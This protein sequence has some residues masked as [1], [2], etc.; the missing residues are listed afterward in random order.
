MEWKNHGKDKDSW[1]DFHRAFGHSTEDCW[2]LRM[3]IEKLVQDGR[4]RHYIRR[5]VDRRGELPTERSKGQSS[6]AFARDKSRSRQRMT[7]HWGTIATII[8]GEGLAPRPKD[9][10]QETGREQEVQAVLT[11]AN[12][13]PLGR[14]DP[15]LVTTEI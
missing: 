12:L 10:M 7:P 6:G 3:Q 9:F 13:T 11:R 8:S 2:T 5:P 14:R 4:L 15:D 1:F